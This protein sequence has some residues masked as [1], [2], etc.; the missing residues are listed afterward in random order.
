MRDTGRRIWSG[1]IT[2]AFVSIRQH[3][4]AYASVSQHKPAY[5]STRQHPPASVRTESTHERSRQGGIG[6]GITRKKN[7]KYRVIPK[8]GTNSRRR[9]GASKASSNSFFLEC[10]PEFVTRHTRPPP[11]RPVQQPFWPAL[12]LLLFLFLCVCSAGVSAGLRRRVCSA[13]AAASVPS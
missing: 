12:F 10:V 7:I 8:R 9:K 6:L 1:A 5:V 2:S 4:P 3:T 11:L 13:A